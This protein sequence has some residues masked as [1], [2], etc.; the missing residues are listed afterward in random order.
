MVLRDHCYTQHSPNPHVLCSREA[1]RLTRSQP[2]VRAK[3]C[4]SRTIARV[5]VCVGRN[6]TNC[7]LSL[8]RYR[9][10]AW[11]EQCMFASL[12]FSSSLAPSEIIEST[13]IVHQC[14]S[15]SCDLQSV[16][17]SRFLHKL[18]SKRPYYS[19]KTSLHNIALPIKCR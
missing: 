1:K 7:R 16:Y 6:M 4:V 10:S 8:I 12:L 15:S 2:K 3:P 5:D 19:E 14:S 9:G 18:S 17:I 11:S 13:V